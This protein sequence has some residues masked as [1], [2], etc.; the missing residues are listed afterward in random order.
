MDVNF[1]FAVGVFVVS[2]ALIC[3]ESLHGT[4]KTVVALCGATAVLV[5]GIVNQHEAFYSSEFGV[6]WNVVFLLLSMMVFVNVMKPTGIFEYVAIKCAQAGKGDP[7]KIMAIFAVVTAVVS[8]F[9]DNVTTVLLIA[10][11]IVT[12]ADRMDIDPVP[13]LISTAMASNIGGTATLIG[14]PPNIM[15]ASKSGLN[16]TDFAYHLAPV[17]C[18]IMVVYIVMIRFLFGKSLYV[19]PDALK[20]VMKLDASSVI[21]DLRLV[22]R[23]LIVL[24]GMIFAFVFHDRINLEPA[25]IAVFGAGI[26]LM[27]SEHAERPHTVLADIE[28][29]SIFFFI[30]LFIIVGAVVK[31]GFIEIMAKAVV[32][33]T[34]GHLFNTSMIMLW[35]S[36][37]ASAI[38]DNIP[39]VATMNPL[40]LD[41]AKQIWPGV[42]HPELVHK[43]VLMPLWWSLALGACL[44]GNGTLIG[45]SA[46]VVAAGIA[47][48]AGRKISFL[49]FMLYSLP[50]WFM[51]IVIA[52]IY[53]WLRYFYFAK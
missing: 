9:I 43:T 37:I 39:F 6:D 49:R 48:K 29:T 27:L 24:G 46:N 7:Y 15:I 52:N 34:G 35:F 32:S 16:F 25:T 53:V 5:F 26:L 40:I 13:F 4:H 36:S 31:V 30:G 45:A 23:S 12:I 33:S 20:K 21:K 22:R 10:P 18:V 11:V 28:W 14:D 51:T 47:E 19:R 3:L 17:I 8:A 41:M 42:A 38:I 1:W 2:Y 44:G 50:V